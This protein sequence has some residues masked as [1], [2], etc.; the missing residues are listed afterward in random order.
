MIY[1]IRYLVTNETGIFKYPTPD[2]H[3]GTAYSEH[4]GGISRSNF[5]AYAWFKLRLKGGIDM[6]PKT[7]ERKVNTECCIGEPLAEKDDQNKTEN[8]W[9]KPTLEEVS[10]QVMAQ[11]YIRFT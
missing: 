5:P 8:K 3:E 6:T 4:R 10:E 9:E 11:P 2:D 7:E 1:L